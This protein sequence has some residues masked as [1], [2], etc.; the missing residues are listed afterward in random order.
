MTQPQSLPIARSPQQL[1]K[2]VAQ[3]PLCSGV[4]GGGFCEKCRSEVDTVDGR[5]HCHNCGHNGGA[6]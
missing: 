1:K 4:L 2:A 5:Y 6:P 3:L